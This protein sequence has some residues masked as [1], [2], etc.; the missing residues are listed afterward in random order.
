MNQTIVVAALAAMVVFTTSC[1]KDN[2]V[3]NEPPAEPSI[4]HVSANRS[5]K[6]TGPNEITLKTKLMTLEEVYAVADQLKE[7][8]MTDEGH[9]SK[10]MRPLAQMGKSLHEELLSMIP[11]EEWEKLSHDEILLITN[12]KPQ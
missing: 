4:A 8:D 1:K 9:V 7:G 6:F 2:S 12:Y 3:R 10:V 5:T 11:Q